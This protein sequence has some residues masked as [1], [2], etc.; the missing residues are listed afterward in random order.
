VLP[1]RVVAW[2][3]RPA[4]PWVALALAV[5]LSLGV[6]AEPFAADD[7]LLWA[8]HAGLWGEWRGPW[9]LFNYFPDDPAIRSQLMDSGVLSWWAHPNLNLS[10]WR[11][12]AS[13]THWLDFSVFGTSAAAHHAH[14]LLWFAAMG[15]SAAVVYRQLIP[16]RWVAALAAALFV[17][18]DVHGVS[19][20]WIASRNLLLAMTFGTLA[21]AAHHRWRQGGGWTWAVAAPGLLALAVLSAEAGIAVVGYLVAYALCL[22]QGP[23]V[24]RLATLAPAGLV[25]IGWRIT[26]QAL[27]YGVVGSGHYLDPVMNPVAF[28][29]RLVTQIPVLVMGHLAASPLDG[30]VVYP[31]LLWVCLVV[32]GLWFAWLWAAFGGLLRS[33]PLARFFLLGMIITAAPLATGVPQDRLLTPIALG[34]FGLIALCLQAV[35]RG[36]IGWGAKALGWIWIAFHGVISPLAL[37]TRAKAMPAL[38]GLSRQIA[39]AMPDTPGVDVVLLNV[40]FDVVSY[41]P[42]AMRTLS[43]EAVPGNLRVLYTGFSDLVLTRTGDHTVELAPRGGFLSTWR[44][45]IARGDEPGFAVG[46]TVVVEGMTARVLAVTAAGRPERVSFTF[47]DPLESMHWL[48]YDADW[49]M[50]VTLPPIGGTFQVQAFDVFAALETTVGGRVPDKAR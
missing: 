35:R 37:P 23:L 24:R 18:E 44:D 26:Y 21:L 7:F 32:G 29:G 20:G 11:P 15:G 30:L 31:H 47:A 49:P 2:L 17:F 19:T 13:I 43:G 9:T 28:V 46:D 25:A 38:G 40:P 3:E 12:L 16:T 6:L 45:R 14:S 5:V 42:H 36:Q 48:T 8:T 27:G 50:P 39:D 34:G 10:F 33:S 1:D 41:Y 4:A 22:E